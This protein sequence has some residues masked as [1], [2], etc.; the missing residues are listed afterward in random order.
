MQKGKWLP[1]LLYTHAME[2]FAVVK[3]NFLKNLSTCMYIKQCFRNNFK[4]KGQIA[5]P[6]ILRK[7]GYMFI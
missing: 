2:Y 7:Y 4:Q 3:K 6:C 1:K 5:E